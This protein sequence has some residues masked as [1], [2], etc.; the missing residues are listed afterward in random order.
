MAYDY[1]SYDVSQQVHKVLS[2]YIRFKYNK[3]ETLLLQ[4][5]LD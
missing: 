1:S 3:N 2:I 5:I 4:L